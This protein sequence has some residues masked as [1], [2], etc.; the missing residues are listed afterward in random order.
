L[1]D[2]HQSRKDLEEQWGKI[3]DGALRI[4]RAF[5]DVENRIYEMRDRIGNVRK[6][7]DRVSVLHIEYKT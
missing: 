6:R 7:L 4:V 3:D 1:N 2:V 5:L